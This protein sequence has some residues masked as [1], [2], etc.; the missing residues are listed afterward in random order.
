MRDKNGRPVWFDDDEYDPD[1][2]IEYQREDDEEDEYEGY[3][4]VYEVDVHDEWV[5]S[6]Y[7]EEGGAV[8]CDLCDSE[9]RWDPERRIW[10][11]P[12]CERAMDRAVYFNYIGANP[13]GP[14][15]IT[16]CLENYPFCKK[17]CERYN[18]PPN[19]PMIS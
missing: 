2:E 6:A 5:N 13:P 1:G 3:A 4:E 14:D 18:I 10:Y 17:Y 15:C 19:D 8:P 7:D 9:M 12:E 16:N 11:C